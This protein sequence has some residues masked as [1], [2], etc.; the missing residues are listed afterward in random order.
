MLSNGEC[1]RVI[2]SSEEEYRRRMFSRK[3]FRGHQDLFISY[4]LLQK[5]TQNISDIYTSEP[6]NIEYSVGIMLLKQYLI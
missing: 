5:Q 4:K 1:L 6:H 3:I 2:Q